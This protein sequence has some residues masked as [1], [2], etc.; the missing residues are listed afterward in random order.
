M[1]KY[2]VPI[3]YVAHRNDTSFDSTGVYAKVYADPEV[4]VWKK[5]SKARLGTACR[6]SGTYSLY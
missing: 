1:G 5:V 3:D 4:V 6:D 2:W